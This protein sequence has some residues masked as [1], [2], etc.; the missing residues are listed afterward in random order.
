[1]RVSDLIVEVRDA[2]RVRVGQLLPKDLVGFT[3]VIRFNA[4]G[5]WSLSL[6]ASHGLVD[7]LRAPGAGL[8]VTGPNGVLLSGPTTSA[9]RSQTQEDPEGSW[10]I[11]GAT[12][13]IVLGERLAYPT[14]ASADVTAQ[15]SEFDTRTGLASTVLY[16]FVSANIGPSAPSARQIAGLTL[17]TDTGLG[18]TITGKARFDNL[19]QLLTRLA[20]TDR[21]GFDL[22]QSGEDIEFSVYQPADRTATV[23]MDID[24]NLLTKSEYTYTSPEATRAIVGGAGAG[25]SRTFSEVSTSTSTAAETAW[26]RRIEVFKDSR[27]TTD[28]GEL[29]QAGTE[30]LAD[31]GKTLEAISVSASD[32]VTMAF[33]VDWNLGD[34]VSVV[35]GSTTISQI[36]TEVGFSIQEDG[37]RIGATVGEPSVADAE[38]ETADTQADQE[39]RISNLERNEGS[40]SGSSGT[41]WTDITGKPVF[42]TASSRDVPASGD[43]T[44]LQVVLGSDSRL[45]AASGKAPIASPTFTGTATAPLIRV[46]SSN[47]VSLAT[48]GH[49]FQIGDDAASNLRMDVNEIMAVNNGAAAGLYLNNDGGTVHTGA[50]LNVNGNA[51]TTN[52]YASSSIYGG[53][54][55]TTT[56]WQTTDGTILLAS[57]ALYATNDGAPSLALSRRTSNGNVAQFYRGSTTIV[58]SISVTTAATAFNTSSDYRLKENVVPIGN[59]CERVKALKPVRFNFIHDEEGETVDG[60]LAHEAQEVVPNAVTGVKDGVDENGDP[61][62]QAID[63]S[64]LVP[65]LTA[66]LQAALETI[67]SLESRITALENR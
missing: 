49:G 33:G 27:S 45:T 35:V 10:A 62:Y 55:T 21:L 48:T 13:A 7:A 25:T 34:K 31:K 51:N 23:R 17:A 9:T 36:V 65:L 6:P 2:S 15:T 40:S 60:F 28:S 26:S 52:L 32:D 44:S 11:S 14:P 42:G 19:G 53:G 47:D 20:S 29:T 64:K 61:E 46:T 38:S 54:K 41:S 56:N 16:G 24:N 63:H 66:A 18:S 39:E 30:E 5:T 1:M 22:K 12:D 67:D 37:V 50:D 59:P 4:P 3:G 58:G 8:I 57:G 43:A